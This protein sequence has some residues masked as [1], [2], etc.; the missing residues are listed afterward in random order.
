MATASC[1]R[2]QLPLPR[3]G[4]GW[5]EDDRDE[6]RP[7]HVFSLPSFTTSPTAR[8][9]T[10]RERQ[11]NAAVREALTAPRP[12]ERERNTDAADIVE[13]FR[14]LAWTLRAESNRNR[15]ELPPAGFMVLLQKTVSFRRLRVH[16]VVRVKN[17]L[18]K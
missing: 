17:L 9:A 14:R 13:T 7:W 10:G 3:A 11:R 12:R 5:G 4:E 18:V 1:R 16:L 8:L 6:E 2:L 15:S